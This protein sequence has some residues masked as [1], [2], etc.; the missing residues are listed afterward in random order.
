MNILPLSVSLRQY[1][2]QNSLHKIRKCY[3]I[4]LT[5]HRMLEVQGYWVSFRCGTTSYLDE[6]LT[7]LKASNLDFPVR[8]FH[9]L[10]LKCVWICYWKSV[11]Q[12]ITGR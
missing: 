1:N 6:L 11:Q 9:D 2:K 7:G 8:S 5:N 4:E 10:N 12:D 3:I